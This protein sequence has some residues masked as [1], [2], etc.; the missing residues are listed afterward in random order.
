[1]SGIGGRGEA[2]DAPSGEP[3]VEVSQV[4]PDRSAHPIPRGAGGAASDV[5]AAAVG[6][7]EGDRNPEMGGGGAFVDERHGDSVIQHSTELDLA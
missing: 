4:V 3:L 6:T 2:I 7:Q 5:A 1:V